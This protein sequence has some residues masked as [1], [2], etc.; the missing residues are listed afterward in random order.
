MK[1]ITDTVNM[2]SIYDSVSKQITLTSL[3]NLAI[4]L[5]HADLQLTTGLCP[6]ETVT[7]CSVQIRAHYHIVVYIDSSEGTVFNLL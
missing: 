1:G 5:C 6:L 2:P 4:L 3:S 7:A